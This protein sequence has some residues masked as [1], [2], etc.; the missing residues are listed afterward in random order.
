VAIERFMVRRIGGHLAVVQVFLMRPPALLNFC[1][2]ACI[3]I[4]DDSPIFGHHL[5]LKRRVQVLPGDTEE[6]ELSAPGVGTAQVQ[7]NL[8]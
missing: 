7:T 8:H 3:P 6:I 1:S 2:C 4:S 5:V